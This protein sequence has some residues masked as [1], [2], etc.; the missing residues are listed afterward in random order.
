MP[1]YFFRFLIQY[2]YAIIFPIA[3]VEGPVITMF[4]GFLVSLGY[5]S[6]VPTYF[7]LLF[8]DLIS[9]SFFYLLGRFGRD[10]LSRRKFFRE[11]ERRLERVEEHYKKHPRKT[12]IVAKASYGVGSFFLAAAGAGKMGYGTFLEYI[13]VPNAVRTLALLLIGFYF[14]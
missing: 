9:D 4:S 3:V 8:G 12:I 7:L 2:K 14:G 6:L 11:S 10:F 5:L 1:R 13:L